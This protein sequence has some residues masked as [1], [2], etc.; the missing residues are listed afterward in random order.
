MTGTRKKPSNVLHLRVTKEQWLKD[1]KTLTRA[2]LGVL[3]YIATSDPFGDR[4]VE[5]TVTE[6]ASDLGL[7]KSSVSRALKQLDQM[8]Y[9]DSELIKAK[10]KV[11]H[12]RN[13]VAPT[14]QT[15]HQRN[16]QCVDA[17]NDAPT[18]QAMH[19][20][21][22]QS[23]DSSPD[24]GSESP[25][26]NKTN[27]T[28]LNSL[29]LFERENF[30]KFGLKKA[31]ELPKKPTLPERWV[32]THF[33]EL[34]PQFRANVGEAIA[35]SQDWENHPRRDEWLEEMRTLGA[36]AFVG[37]A[38]GEERSERTKFREWAQANNRIW[39]NES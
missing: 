6:I 29:S 25:Q 22:N 12:P 37:L 14:Q 19:S 26:T 9:I 8:R 13:T 2:Q 16:L 36:G 3:Y 28:H 11:L 21:N 17:T 1:F 23:S 15:M 4:G 18:Q 39:G 5:V 20:H 33:D 27:K 35:P 38:P 30:L 32:W 24:K 7:D 10:V 34:Y 31:A